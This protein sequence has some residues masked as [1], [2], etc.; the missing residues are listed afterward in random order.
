LLMPESLPDAYRAVLDAVSDHQISVARI[1]ESV[2]RILTLKARLGLFDNP[3]TTSQAADNSV[4]TR[5]QLATMAAAARRAITLV[6]NDDDALPLTDHSGKH[7]LVT[8]WGEGSTQTLTADIAGHGV[9]AQRLYTGTTPSTATIAAAVAAAKTNDVVVV[10]TDNAS[11]NT[12][13]QALVTALLGTGKPVIVA[14]LGTPYDI[15]YFNQAPTFLAAY[16]YQPNTL[17]ALADTIFGAEPTGR[18]PV[19]VP[20]AGD[21]SQPLFRYG[22]G[23]HYR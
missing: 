7:V 21:V 20:L 11:G 4:G 17:A 13:Q 12:A 23:L 18:L 15:G 2:R 9:T 10:T 8:G 22:T 14:A 1:N 3:Y 16:G 19:T 5:G 6:K